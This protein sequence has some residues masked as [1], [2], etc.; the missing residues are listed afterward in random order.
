MQNLM[1]MMECNMKHVKSLNEKLRKCDENS[2]EFKKLKMEFNDS[3]K[4]TNMLRN[5]YNHV[6]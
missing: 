6:M 5:H 4:M 1:Q 2:E 3:I